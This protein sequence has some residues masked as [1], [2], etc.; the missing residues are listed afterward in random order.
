MTIKLFWRGDLWQSS[1]LRTVSFY[2]DK[3]SSERLHFA[4]V[5]SHLLPVQNYL[6]GKV[7]FWYGIFCYPLMGTAKV[8]ENG[9]LCPQGQCF[10]EHYPRNLLPPKHSRSE[11]FVLIIE[12][13]MTEVIIGT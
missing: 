3:E 4:S 10:W 5:D 7:T 6:Y 2:I 11:I 9:F 12:K 8:K 1:F 13:V